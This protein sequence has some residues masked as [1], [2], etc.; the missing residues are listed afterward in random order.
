ME[1]ENPTQARRLLTIDETADFLGLKRSTLYHWR[2]RGIGPVSIK[3]GQ[4]V[5]YSEADLL[6]WLETQKR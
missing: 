5:R 2:W 4:R 3:V 6:E 1:H